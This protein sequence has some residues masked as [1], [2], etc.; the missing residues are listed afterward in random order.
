MALNPN[1]PFQLENLSEDMDILGKALR[2]SLLGV[3]DA[4]AGR[5][6]A[7]ALLAT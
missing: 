7:V 6:T 3:L 1:A 2:E 5:S 4:R